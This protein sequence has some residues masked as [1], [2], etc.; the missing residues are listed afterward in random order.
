MNNQKKPEVK[1]SEI[2]KLYNSGLS[3][4]QIGEKLGLW[5]SSVGRRLIKAGI[6]LRKSKDYSGETR[7]WLWKGNDYIDPITRK[8]NQRVLRKWSKDVR[9]RDE[10]KCTNCNSTQKLDA[11]HIIPIEK[12]I[13]SNL[14]FDISNG[15]TLCHKCHLSLHKKINQLNK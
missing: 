15:I 6:N 1:T 9:T 2:I 8:R 10:N 4:K 14:E 13:D 5:K 3:T 11:H 7:Y 12:C